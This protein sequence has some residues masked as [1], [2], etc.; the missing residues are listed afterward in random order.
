[1]EQMRVVL[2]DKSTNLP[3]PKC[4]KPNAGESLYKRLNNEAVAFQEHKGALK[5]YYSNEEIRGCSFAPQVHE[6]EK[7]S[8]YKF[9]SDQQNHVQKVER[10]VE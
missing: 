5:E 2:G 1:M 10:Q 6:S 8:L 7:R 4:P 3:K 9:L